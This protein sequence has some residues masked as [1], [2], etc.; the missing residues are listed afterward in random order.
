MNGVMR[1]VT[2]S[3]QN[4]ANGKSQLVDKNYDP[5]QLVSFGYRD[6]ALAD[7]CDLDKGTT[8]QAFNP[9]VSQPV[10]HYIVAMRT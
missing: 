4:E 8:E 6:S 10:S 1:K 5:Y 7:E 2:N 9:Q 3:K